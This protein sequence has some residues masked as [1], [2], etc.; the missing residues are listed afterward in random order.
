MRGQRLQKARM[1]LFLS[2][3]C[4]NCA[5]IE[6][7]IGDRTASGERRKDSELVPVVRNSPI[8]WQDSERT[9]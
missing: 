4:P 1:Q 7:R 3:S 9:G 5:Q 8:L 6:F 2:Q